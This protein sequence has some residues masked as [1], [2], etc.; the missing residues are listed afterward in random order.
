M[1]C[2][3][4]YHGEGW[5]KIRGRRRCACVCCEWEEEV[6]MEWDEGISRARACGGEIRDAGV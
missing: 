3:D 2:C 6:S 4:V 5:V 1:L